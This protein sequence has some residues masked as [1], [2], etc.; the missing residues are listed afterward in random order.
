MWWKARPLLQI[1]VVAGV[2]AF[3]FVGDIAF[4]SGLNPLVVPATVQRDMACY[5]FSTPLS[6]QSVQQG[7][8]FA[9]DIFSRSDQACNQ[10]VCTPAPNPD[11]VELSSSRVTLKR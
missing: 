3:N 10:L 1:C 7:R 8:N 6:Q 2:T 11:V 9:C 5:S 4:L